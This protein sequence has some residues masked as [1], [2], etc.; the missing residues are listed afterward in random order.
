[1]KTSTSSNFL[2]KLLAPLCAAMLPALLATSANAQNILAWDFFGEGS[3]TNNTSVADVYAAGLDSTNV[4]SRGP[5]APWSTGQN[6]FRTTGFGNNGISTTN[7]DYFQFSVSATNGKILSLSSINARFAGTAGFVT[8]NN[9]GATNQF[10]Y[11]TNG[12]NWALIATP[13][14]VT[15]TNNGSNWVM[16]VALSGIAELQNLPATTTASFRF[17]ASGQTTTGGWGFNSPTNNPIT[18]GLSVGGTIVDSGVPL[19]TLSSPSLALGT[20][21]SG[22]ASVPVGYTVSGTNLGTTN[23]TVTSGS[24]LV[25]I[26]TN[27]TTG[28]STNSIELLPSAGSVAS[29]TIFAR[30]ASTAP[31]TNSFSATIS[32]ISGA[33]ATNI[34]VTGSVEPLALPVVTPASYNGQVGVV[35]SNAVVATGV[36]TNYVVTSGTLPAGLSLSPTTGVISGTPT[37]AVTASVELTAGNAAG[38]SAPA[39]F[40]FAIAKGSQT[41]SFSALPSKVVGDADFV[42]AATASSGLPVSFSSSNEAVATVAG[43]TVTIVGPGSAIITA[44]QAGDDNWDPAVSVNQTLLVLPNNIAYWNFGTQTPTVSPAGW[45][46]GAVNYGNNNGTNALI[47]SSSP[48]S[49]Y[50]NLY[51]I[52]ASG[53]SNASAAARTGAINT[54]TNGSAYFEF[55]VV[56]PSDSTN[57]AITNISFGSRSTGTGPQSYSIRSS[58]DNFAADLPGGS[59]VLVANN[60]WANQSASV[61]VFMTNG[62]TNT[63][64]IYGFGGAGSAAQHSANWRIDDLTVGTGA[65]SATNPSIVLTPTAVSGLSTFSGTPSAGAAYSL[66]G[67]NLTTNVVVTPDT[68]NL[69]VSTNNLNFTNELTLVPVAGVLSNM[70]LYVRIASAAPI[71]SLTGGVG[72]STGTVTSTLGVTGN[73]FD[74]SRG[75]STNSL[76]AWDAFTQT[77]FGPS[78]W[79]PTLQASNL[80]VSTGLTRGSGVVVSGTAAARAWGGSDWVAAD[81]ASAIASNKFVTFTIAATNGHTLSVSSLSKFDYRRSGNGPTTALIQAQV[82]SNNDFIDLATV[83]FTSTATSGASLPAIDLSTNAA[84]QNVPANTPVTL[85]VV[86][87]LA[88]SNS[89]VWYIYDVGNNPNVDFEISGSVAPASTPPA[90]S[91]LSYTPSSANGVVGTSIT[92][93]VPSV[94]GN[95]TNYAVSPTLP[96]G[97][98]IDSITGEISG[99]PTT[100]TASAGYTVTAANAGGSTTANVTIAVAKATPVINSAPT[101]SGLVQGQT[102]A[103]STLSGGSAS[104]PGTFVWTDSSIVPPVGTAIYGVTFT[105]SDGANYN[106]ATTSASV[107]VL[108]AYQAGYNNWLTGFQLDPLVTTG[109]NAGAP[110]ADPDNDGFSNASEYAFGTNPKVPNG[111]L[112]TTS[113]SNSVFRSSWAGPASGVSY[114]VQFSTNLSTMAFSNDPTI[115]I[116]SVGGVMSFTNQATGNKFFRVRATSN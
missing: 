72:H 25:E 50:V 14:V 53:T 21:L 15:G 94:T 104:V 23:I 36:P 44:D 73:V 40:D 45:S 8:N 20:T 60:V 57:L 91:G 71:G 86:N 28:F 68:A 18:Y 109:P 102:L 31:A 49:G 85:R 5:G 78:P 33:A 67:T 65:L 13:V 62:V 70:T 81:P 114:G 39:T 35:F 11:S 22:T 7:T 93:M 34:A 80:I 19:I 87:Y 99:T 116:Q 108:S 113:S 95:V 9:A 76:V 48:S 97:L 4:L 90:P 92:S 24:P 3:T 84:L 1:M 69:E 38:T 107:T 16:N 89:G 30:I 115:T 58:A 51:G 10:A 46:F 79:A 64:R 2:R 101:A 27:G 29:T 100:A 96:A 63:F 42:L 74:P 98:S 43:N 56:A 106:T 26:S 17:Y 111:A 77:N 83:D 105:P 61:S 103:L 75:A 112:L 6:S 55:T 52:S 59:G 12:T 47:T 88:A 41:I 54:N 32:H 110:N 37:A 82:G 66:A